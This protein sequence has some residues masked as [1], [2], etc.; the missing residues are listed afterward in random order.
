[1]IGLILAW[2]LFPYYSATAQAPDESAQGSTPVQPSITSEDRSSSDGVKKPASQ[3]SNR[4]TEPKSTSEA[5]GS[6]SPGSEGD[7]SSVPNDK[8]T[9]HLMA[10]IATVATILCIAGILY[11]LFLKKKQRTKIR[12]FGTRLRK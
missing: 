6:T 2:T 9:M 4:Y 3:S 12:A 7:D 10:V 5:D 1:M 11:I 8:G